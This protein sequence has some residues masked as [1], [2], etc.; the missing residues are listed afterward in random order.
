MDS[1]KISRT[2]LEVICQAVIYESNQTNAVCCRNSLPN[3]RDRFCK[4]GKRYWWL[5]SYGIASA[6]I[7][8]ALWRNKY[9]NA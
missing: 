9:D 4:H 1:I 6:N 3:A 8:L 7:S 2:S 5:N